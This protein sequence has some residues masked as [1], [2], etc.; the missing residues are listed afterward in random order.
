V[1]TIPLGDTERVPVRVVVSPLLNVV[2]SVLTLYLDLER[3]RDRRWRELLERE[4]EGVDRSALSYFALGL[5]LPDFMAPL[6][7]PPT[8]TFPEELSRLRLAAPARVAGDIAAE[9]DHPPAELQP[10]L[11]RPQDALGAYA[12]ALA[13]F[14]SRLYAPRWPKMSSLLEREVLVVGRALAGEGV[15]ASLRNRHPM[16]RLVDDEVHLEVDEART[17]DLGGRQLVLCPLVVGE[18]RILWNV[19][20]PD[21]V[22]LG[23]PAPGSLTLWESHASPVDERLASVVGAPRARILQVLTQPMTMTDL[24][25]VLDLSPGSVAPQLLALARAGLLSRTPTGR[26]VYYALSDPGRALVSSVAATD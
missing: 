11:E 20:G 6:P 7:A 9:F 10:F 25:L 12:D 26:R 4:T 21:R 8:A 13:A 19:D 16:I 3:L 5:P 2:L 18:N 17:V 24:T 22:V 1:L 23:Y 15:A 14:W